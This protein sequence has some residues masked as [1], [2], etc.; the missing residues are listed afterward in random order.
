MNRM[1]IAL[2]ATSGI[3]CAKTPLD[4]PMKSN[5]VTY[6]GAAA[7]DITPEIIETFTDVNGDHN[8]TGCL[9]DPTASGTNCL[10]PFD[11]VD[12]DGWFD[13]V[14]IGGFGPMRPANGVHDPIYARA[15]VLSHNESYIA[16]VSLDLVGLGS[17]RIHEAR[18]RL[19]AEG[20]DLDRLLG[21][22]T[23]NHQGP[24]TMGLWGN[25]VNMAAP[26]S[27]ISEAYQERVTDSIE[28][29][30][31]EAAASMVPVDL[32]VGALQLRDVS[33]YYNGESFGGVN[34][35]KKM[36]GLIHDVRDPVL[37]SDQLLV[38]QGQGEDGVV[39]TWT[40]WSGHPEVRG[41]SNNDIS[42]DWPGPMREAIEARHGGI[43]V[44]MPESLGGMQSALG[45]DV[46]LY[47]TEGQ[48][49]LEQCD[50]AAVANAEDAACF[51]HEVGSTR[52]YVDSPELPVPVWASHGSWDFVRSHGLVL[53][54]AVDHALE[55]SED[56]VPDPIRVEAESLYVPINNL[57]YQLLGPM[58]LFDLGLEDA[59][60]DPQRCPDVV[61]AVNGGAGCV[62]TRTFRVQIGE[63]GLVAVPG[64]L[65]PELARGFP[66]EDPAWA[67]EADDPAQ[68]GPGA[69]Y[70]PQHDPDCNTV[71]YDDCQTTDS[72]GDC[73]CLQ[74]HRWP[75]VIGDELDTPL[76]EPL[77]TRYRAI[78]GMTDN[79]LSYIIPEPDFNHSV[80][81]LSS[82]DG[83]H[84]ED[85]VSPASN[86]GTRL[87]HAQ[88]TI[89]NRW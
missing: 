64:E 32:R 65:L 71:A 25:P 60:T 7:I 47:D 44:H 67:I 80:S 11:D 88:E 29:A 66:T 68:R 51:G 85:T 61:D 34:P 59:I 55:S 54:D 81:L 72:I 77:D 53:A 84:Y 10:E 2:I 63:V 26:V 82:D 28:R 4:I 18:D 37:V 87:L 33:P 52:Y 86:F 31:R 20:F 3:G 78:L 15:V 36:H 39:F 40:N 62:E 35:T 73:D 5:D 22:S 43:A 9:D 83:D 49:V 58:G 41:S 12:G 76:L 70:F 6:A 75:Y 13:A 79:Y 19:V 24:D 8:F 16:L 23:H 69:R 89:S 56:V 45:G 14:F 57:V 17:P 74:I 1:L 27:G 38:M 48:L 50:E 42:S 30:V 46:P 21:A